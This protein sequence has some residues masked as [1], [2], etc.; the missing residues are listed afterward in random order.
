LKSENNNAKMVM[1]VI[2]QEIATIPA[3]GSV[4]ITAIP[5]NIQLM[6]KNID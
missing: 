1:L 2:T 4:K 6:K 5:E 3:G